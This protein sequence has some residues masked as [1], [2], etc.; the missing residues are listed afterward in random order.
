MTTERPMSPLT[1][2][3]IIGRATISCANFNA[4]K[5]KA[6]ENAVGLSGIHRTRKIRIKSLGWNMTV[7]GGVA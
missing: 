4:S 6:T 1:E 3:E 5:G 7:G 2:T